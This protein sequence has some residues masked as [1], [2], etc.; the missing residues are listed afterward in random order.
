M[1]G[2]GMWE[3]GPSTNTKFSLYFVLYSHLV[4][5]RGTPKGQKCENTTNTLPSDTGRDIKNGTCITFSF[6]SSTYEKKSRWKESEK[7][8]TREFFFWS[9]FFGHLFLQL[10]FY[11]QCYLVYWREEGKTV[12]D[13]PLY[14]LS[15]P[16]H[17]KWKWAAVFYFSYSIAPPEKNKKKWMWTKEKNFNAEE[18]RR[19]PSNEAF[20]KRTRVE[21]LVY[22]NIGKILNITLFR[23]LSVGML[24]LFCLFSLL[25]Y[26]QQL[27]GWYYSTWRHTSNVCKC[28][29]FCSELFTR[30]FL[31]YSLSSF[32][33]VTF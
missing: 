15:L 6:S 27:L 3:N 30:K 25:L 5:P 9:D 29:V 21:I 20:F 2:G 8:W 4:F 16:R 31:G 26:M 7:R 17:T 33:F 28:R 23:I 11:R 22:E 12:M 10:P 1:W 18:M 19:G 24:C 14:P 13:S 32:H